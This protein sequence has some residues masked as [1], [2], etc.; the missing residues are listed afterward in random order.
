MT[1]DD[2]V[3]EKIWLEGGKAHV[4]RVANLMNISFDYARSILYSLGRRDYIDI[5]TNEIAVLTHKGKES[6]EKQGIIPKELNAEKKK[7]KKKEGS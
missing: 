1:N 3:L 6:L 2:E 4:H 7:K 5:G